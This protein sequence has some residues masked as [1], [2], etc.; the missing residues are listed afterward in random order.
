[1]T[2]HLEAPDADDVISQALAWHAQGQNTVIATVVETWRSAPCPVGSQLV[3]SQSGDFAGSVSGGCVEGAVITEALDLMGQSGAKVLTFG[4]ADSDAFTVGLACGGTIKL[5]LTPVGTSLPVSLLEQIAVARLRREGIGYRVDMSTGAHDVLSAQTI[6]EQ[7]LFPEAR[8]QI[9]TQVYSPRTRLVVVGAGHIAQHLIPMA[10][11]AGLETVLIDPRAAFLT[12]TRFRG[13][14]L[15]QGLLL[16]D[17]DEAF[18]DLGIDRHTAVVVLAHDPKIDDPALE[19][20]LRSPAPY[21][22]ALGSTRSHAKRVKRLKKAGFSA[23]E[24][25]RIWGPVGVP[26][27]ARTP[28][29]IAVSILAQLV[30]EMQ[31]TA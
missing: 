9:F 23:T 30:Q 19:R 21:I 18:D 2:V 13:E 12:P 4:V 16:A 3:I 10:R 17:A 27:A 28:A 6:E 7:S 20:A 22:G 24:I 5:C 14:R 25:A 11:I 31:K 15:G 29:E 26:I 8:G 1:M